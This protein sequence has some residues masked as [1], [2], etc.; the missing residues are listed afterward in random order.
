[1]NRPQE[2]AGREI[3][4]RTL[5]ELA[6]DPEYMRQLT[7]AM[8]KLTM[9]DIAVVCEDVVNRSAETLS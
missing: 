6:Q 8:D 7:E 4:R 9:D 5:E 2:P 3:E 1:M